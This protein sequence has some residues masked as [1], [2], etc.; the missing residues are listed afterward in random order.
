MPSTVWDET[1]YLFPKINDAIE[2]ISSHNFYGWNCLSIVVLK[3]I[4][5]NK[6]GV[7]VVECLPEKGPF[8]FHGR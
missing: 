2:V 7:Q 5:V 8:I 1:T 6:V 4:H 3:L